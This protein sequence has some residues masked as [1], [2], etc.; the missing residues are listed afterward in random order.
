MTQ[1]SSLPQILQSGSGIIAPHGSATYCYPRFRCSWTVQTI[2]LTIH[3]AVCLTALETSNMVT[4]FPSIGGQ[5]KHLKWSRGGF[6]HKFPQGWASTQR[7]PFQ[8]SCQASLRMESLGMFLCAATA[9]R[10][11]FRVPILRGVCA[12]TAMRWGAGCWV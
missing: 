1:C 8:Q 2:M 7:T 6:T 10:I 4:F 3:G 9:E 12:G 11:A 5:P